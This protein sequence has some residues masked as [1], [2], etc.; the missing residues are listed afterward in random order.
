MRTKAEGVAIR[1]LTEDGRTL[2][3]SVIRLNSD[4]SMAVAN[5]LQNVALLE[6]IPVRKSYDVFGRLFWTNTE[7]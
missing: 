5:A 3:T 6:A 2:S 7:G 1:T 4:Q